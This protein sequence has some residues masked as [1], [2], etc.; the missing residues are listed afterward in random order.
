[1][2]EGGREKESEETPMLDVQRS[3]FTR[4]SLASKMGTRRCACGNS[5]KSNILSGLMVDSPERII[6]YGE[7][8][9]E[10]CHD[11]IDPA[12]FKAVSGDR[13]RGKK[14]VR[15]TLT[16][17]QRRYPLDASSSFPPPPADRT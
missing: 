6:D 8:E 14:E 4:R 9:L 3:T 13:E 11:S 17:L 5:E 1:M 10:I 15:P 16:F 7:S 12:V 2:R